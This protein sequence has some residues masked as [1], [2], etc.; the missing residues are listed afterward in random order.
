MSPRNRFFASSRRRCFPGL[1]L[2]LETDKDTAEPGASNRNQVAI[3]RYRY[4]ATSPIWKGSCGK[5]EAM[6][7][8]V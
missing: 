2:L 3:S 7:M 6:L 1:R 5:V 8:F 4:F